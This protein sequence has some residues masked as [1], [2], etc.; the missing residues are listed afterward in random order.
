M[1]RRLRL[2]TV[3]AVALFCG[4][5]VTASALAKPAPQSCAD[6][7]RINLRKCTSF[8]VYDSMPGGDYYTGGVA[9][10]AGSTGG[11][12]GIEDPAAGFMAP[13]SENVLLDSL[14]LPLIYLSGANKLDV[15]LVGES[16]TGSSGGEPYYPNDADVLEHWYLDNVLVAGNGRVERLTST[17]HP[18]LLKGLR[19]WVYISAREPIAFLGW[20]AGSLSYTG[21][22]WWSVRGGSYPNWF[23]SFR[24]SGAARAIRVTALH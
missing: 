3:A 21:P 20:F 14:E 15:F 1:G 10:T 6:A 18:K 16:P 4:T 13:V 9:L 24:E 22:G 11:V 2:A 17:V 12:I 8:V 7:K 5:L 23:T 19:Y